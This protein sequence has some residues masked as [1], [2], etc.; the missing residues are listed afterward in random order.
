MNDAARTFGLRAASAGERRRIQ[1]PDR[2]YEVSR[3]PA[4]SATIWADVK[5]WSA[6]VGRGFRVALDKAK[7]AAQKTAQQ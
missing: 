5:S 2:L 3:L 7:K 1:P 6:D 4:N